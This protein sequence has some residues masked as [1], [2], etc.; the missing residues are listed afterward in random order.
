MFPT[1][2]CTRPSNIDDADT[3]G[4]A[5][6]RSVLGSQDALASA[7]ASAFGSFV[8]PIARS[9]L[10]AS[11][12]TLLGR[13]GRCWGFPQAGSIG[14]SPAWSEAQKAAVRIYVG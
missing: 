8:P 11:R 12:V 14:S 10:E 13:D 9:A 2:A 1:H 3:V 5:T 7:L 6:Q 4:V